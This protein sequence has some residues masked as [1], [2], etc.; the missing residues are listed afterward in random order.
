MSVQ[1]LVKFESHRFCLDG[2]RGLDEI[3]TIRIEEL[4]VVVY[5][6]TC[7]VLDLQLNRKG[8]DSTRYRLNCSS[9]QV[10]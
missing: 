4:T 1:S 9:R 2:R 6:L 7:S 3:K 5:Y 8:R 10:K